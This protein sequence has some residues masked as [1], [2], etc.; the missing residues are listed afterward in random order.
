M[1]RC[2]A[3]VMDASVN[4]ILILDNHRRVCIAF[5]QVDRSEICVRSAFGVTYGPYGAKG[6]LGP[7]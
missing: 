4:L 7:S 2:E 5:P 6:V 3:S 1:V